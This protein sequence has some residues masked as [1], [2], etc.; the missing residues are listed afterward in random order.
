MAVCTFSGKAPFSQHSWNTVC[1]N[2]T[3]KPLTKQLAAVTGSFPVAQNFLLQWSKPS[4]C[5]TTLGTGKKCNSPFFASFELRI[6]KLPGNIL[7]YFYM[8]RVASANA[9]EVM[10]PSSRLPLTHF[11]LISKANYAINKS[12]PR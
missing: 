4:F 5:A 1:L 8:Q 7:V 3:K 6:P 2:R 10:C 9:E 11:Q 12:F